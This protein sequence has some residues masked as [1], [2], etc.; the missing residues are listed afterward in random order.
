M[1]KKLLSGFATGLFVF[2]VIGTA[3]ATIIDLNAFDATASNPVTVSLSLAAG[4][5]DVEAIGV[6]EGGLYNSWNAWGT[7]Y[8]CDDDGVNCRSGWIN[9]YTYSSDEIGVL[10]FA[11]GN[12]Y[13]TDL[14]ALDYAVDSTFTLSAFAVVDFY[15]SDSTYRNNLGGM[16][17]MVTETSAPVPEP[18]TMLLFGTGLIGLAGSRF[19]RKKK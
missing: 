12:R 9:G 7:V 18:A 16:S 14:L 4:T 13:E 19:R 5:Y 8:G 1:K 11:D 10:T 2:G 15:I 6:T 17:L 3:S